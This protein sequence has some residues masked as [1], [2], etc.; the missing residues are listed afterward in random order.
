[1]RRLLLLFL[2]F[3]LLAHAEEK[4]ISAPYKKPVKKATEE[5]KAESKKAEDNGSTPGEEDATGE[6]KKEESTWDKAKHKAEDA[7]EAIAEGAQKAK[8]SLAAAREL[9]EERVWNITGNYQLF[10]MWVLTKYGFTLGY[11][12]SPSSTY[13]FELM[14]G[15]IGLG[16]FGIDLAEI[17]ETRMSLIWRSYGRRNSFNFITGV[18]YNDLE[19]GYGSD[20]L[21]TVPGGHVDAISIK[22]LG[23]TWGLG[24]RWVTR[25][26]FI[27]G[28]DWF[29][30]NI[31]LVV[32]ESKNA[33]VDSTSNAQDRSDAQ[34]A[35]DL[36]ERFPEF[37]AI[38]VQLG[39]S[40]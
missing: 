5:K 33:F 36:F 29:H 8:K 14:H 13:E 32:L 31:P 34:D 37:A 22:T 28:F 12:A 16:K 38:K 27:W 7:G 21:S 20:W 4:R 2:A 39:F 40:W 11:N 30:V 10:E 26:G 35:Q 1:M 17:K 3:S 25:S 19:A 18:F 15:S 23:I 24:N 9:R 6:E